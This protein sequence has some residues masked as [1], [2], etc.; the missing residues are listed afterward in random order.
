MAW[1]LTCLIDTCETKP[2]HLEPHECQCW[3]HEAQESK[4]AVEA[5]VA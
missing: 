1:S 3:C 2:C 4:E 5:P